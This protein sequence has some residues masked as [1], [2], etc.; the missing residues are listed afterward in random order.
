MIQHFLLPINPEPW[1]TPPYSVGRNRKT[2]QPIVIAGRD[3]TGFMFKEAAQEEMV[4]QGAQKVDPP[5][6]IE[7]WFW[8]HLEEKAKETDATNMQKLLEDAMQGIILN[9]DRFVRKISSNNM[10]QGLDVPGMILIEVEDQ[11]TGNTP[12]P[13]RMLERVDQMHNSLKHQIGTN[14]FDEFKLNNTWP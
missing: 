1:K 7:F 9:D 3:E 4:L 2:K 8:R 11:F 13:D 6:R 12:I 5:Y 10:E 14:V